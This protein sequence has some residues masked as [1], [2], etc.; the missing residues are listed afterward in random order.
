MEDHIKYFISFAAEVEA[1][2]RSIRDRGVQ[3]CALDQ[4]NRSSTSIFANFAESQ[5]SNTIPDCR[6]KL[7]L[8]LK[9]AVETQSWICF[10][11]KIN[12]ID[13]DSYDVM[14]GWCADIIQKLDLAVFET[15][16]NETPTQWLKILKEMNETKNKPKKQWG[17]KV[18]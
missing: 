18:N 6:N 3:H 10:L 8:S 17:K 11:D 1:M 7:A 4:I 15:Y 12:L 2:I 14:S 13:R 5:R 9:E 16:Q